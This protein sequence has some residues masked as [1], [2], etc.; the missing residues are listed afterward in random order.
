[1]V[2]WWLVVGTGSGPTKTLYAIKKVTVKERL[3]VKL[4]FNLPAGQHGLKLFLICDSYAGADQDFEIEKIKVE[5]GESSDEEESEE[6][7]EGV[8]PM[9]Q[10]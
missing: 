3:E 8:E 6:E 5:E 7:G 9:E 2:S 1:M 10:D 4:E